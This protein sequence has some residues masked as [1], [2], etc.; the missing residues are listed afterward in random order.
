VSFGRA[1]SIKISR[2]SMSLIDLGGLVEKQ[3]VHSPRDDFD[4]GRSG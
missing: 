2:L 4:E 3:E 1:E